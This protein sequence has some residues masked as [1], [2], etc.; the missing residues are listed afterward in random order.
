VRTAALLLIAACAVAGCTRAHY[1]RSADRETYPTIAEHVVSPAYAIGRTRVEPAPVSRIADPFDPDHPPKPPDDP[2]SAIFMARPNGM[3]GAR[4]GR[5]GYADQVEPAGW[6]Q[7]LRP[8][9]DGTVRLDQDSAVEIAL[10]NSREYQT[11]VEDVYLQALALTLNRFEFAVRWFGTNTTN[12]THFG[13]GGFPTETNT[14]ASNSALGFNKSFA[15][16]GQLL[17]DFANSLVYE[18][19]G[20]SAQ[21]RSNIL[22]NFVQPLL[23]NAGRRVRLED[24][25]QAER[26]TLYAVRTFARFRKQFWSD[27]AIQNGGYLN[28]LLALQTLRNNQ[29]NLT[30]QEE[31]YRLYSELYAGGRA[32][33]VELNQSYQSFQGARGSVVDAQVTLQNFQDSFKLKLGIP[34]RLP[35]ELDD[36]LLNRFVLTDPAVEALQRDL[37]AFQ[38]ARL[39]EL[40]QPPTVEVLNRAF[41]ALHRLADAV[42]AALTSTTSDY[43][44]WG[45][46]LAR[47]PRAGDDPDQ[48][49]RAQAAHDALNGSLPEMAADLARLVAAIERER[50]KVAEGTRKASWEALT[51]LSRD[52][53]A[54]VDSIIAVQTQARIYLIELPELALDEHTALQYAHENRL[55]LQ[56]Q[57]ATVTDAWRKVW[58]AA[59]ALRGDLNV[60]TSANVATD[61]DH[62]GPFN[63]SSQAS[64]YS[65]GLQ[66]AGPLNRQAERNAYRASIITY[67]RARRS[68]MALS[69]RIEQSV[70]FD[71]RNL[72]RLRITF[73]ISRQTLLSAARQ[74]ENAR[75]TLLGPR[76]RRAANDATTINLLNALTALVN[77]RNGLA[78]SYINF[79]QLRVQL[80]LDLEELQLDPRGFPANVPPIPSR[81][82]VPAPGPGNAPDPGPGAQPL[83]EPRR[84]PVAPPAAP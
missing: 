7:V 25:T 73:E 65:V 37:E 38:R 6:E 51:A 32:S 4:W 20:G 83:P 57:L 52:A 45:R 5:D 13:T 18:Y 14:L 42:P 76:D 72:N 66:F 11:A 36:S 1:R 63:Y 46:Q 16:G 43:A 40:D 84:L 54:I 34:P 47:P 24:L 58:V 77:A 10:L 60:V 12:Y 67:Q 35:V 48:R 39:S 33:V 8:G 69:D 31:V 82:D 3:L 80:L 29:A 53:I 17:V 74:Y 59:N 9:P 22:V 64:T 81:D 26:D 75:L 61:P 27:V 70:R 68:Y 71:I 19:T 23:R 41:V 49:D 2:A 28:L 50:G 30:R 79:E 44:R 62:T 15:A 21:V 56:N 55:D 78:T